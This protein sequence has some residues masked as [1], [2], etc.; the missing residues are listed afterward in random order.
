MRTEPGLAQDISR[1]TGFPL[2]S[3]IHP[4]PFLAGPRYETSVVGERA[5]GGVSDRGPR[6]RH[7]KRQG[8]AGHRE[9]PLLVVD[10]DRLGFLVNPAM[11]HVEIAETVADFRQNSEIVH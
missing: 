4:D 3:G 2:A 6:S 8:R 5:D 10:G 7:Q 1:E 9:F 11:F